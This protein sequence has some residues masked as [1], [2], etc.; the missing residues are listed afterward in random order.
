[1]SNKLG[2]CV[3]RVNRMDLTMPRT[4]PSQPPGRLLQIP[5]A[6]D[7]VPIEH[8]ARLVPGDLH[9]DP[10]GHAGV[11]EVPHRGPPEVVPIRPRNPGRLARLEL[12]RF[13]GHPIVGEE[14]E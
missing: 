12:T 4:M 8:A 11:D 14:S 7:V 5:W 10:L 2:T 3:A 13:R 1:M 9:R 6:H